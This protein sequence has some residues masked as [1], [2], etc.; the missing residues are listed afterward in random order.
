M[1]IEEATQIVI[2]YEKS[3][4]SPDGYTFVPRGYNET[5]TRDSYEIVYVYL[6]NR[7]II[8]YD[9]KN[10]EPENIEIVAQ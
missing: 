3:N 4:I 2:N 1:S 8:S 10:G 6:D 9:L 5:Q 7:V